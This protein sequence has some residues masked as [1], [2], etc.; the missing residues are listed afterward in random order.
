MI[1][2]SRPLTALRPLLLALLVLGL[3][4]APVLSAIGNTHDLLHDAAAGAHAHDAAHVSESGKDGLLHAAMHCATC[5]AH[6]P[7]LPPQPV[8]FSPVGVAHPDLARPK[9]APARA[10]DTLLRPPI[11]G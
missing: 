8:V 11:S 2:L 6:V 1:R 9:A 10:P 5:G 4:C 7:A 3:V